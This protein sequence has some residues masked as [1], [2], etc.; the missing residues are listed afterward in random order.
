MVPF[1]PLLWSSAKRRYHGN[2]CE[3]G[4]DVFDRR[5]LEGDDIEI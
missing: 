2:G 1:R 5:L 4:E 3:R